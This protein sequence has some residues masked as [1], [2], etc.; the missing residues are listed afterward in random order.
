MTYQIFRVDGTTDKVLETVASFDR[1]RDAW[2][3][4]YD[5][6]FSNFEI[7]NGTAA[8]YEASHA[9]RAAESRERHAV[10]ASVY[11]HSFA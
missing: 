8:E 6:P 11:R 4:A 1:S 3:A 2:A 10:Q 9:E 5:L 7:F